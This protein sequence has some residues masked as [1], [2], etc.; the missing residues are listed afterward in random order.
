MSFVDLDAEC[1]HPYGD[2]SAHLDIHGYDAYAERNVG[3][4]LIAI[5]LHCSIV[6]LRLSDSEQR[7]GY[8]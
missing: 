4:G 5:F 3:L 8:R 2:I 6:G 1:S 7:R